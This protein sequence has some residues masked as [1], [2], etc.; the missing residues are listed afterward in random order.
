MGEGKGREA[1]VRQ[2]QAYWPCRAISF[3]KNQGGERVGWE[4]ARG[5]KREKAWQ[6]LNGPI[7]PVAFLRAG[8]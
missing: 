1:K 7:G 5:E 4:K 2:V 8:W 3:F 6:R